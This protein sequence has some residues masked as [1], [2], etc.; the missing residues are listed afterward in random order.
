MIEL[1]PD[2]SQTMFGPIHAAPCDPYFR[3]GEFEGLCFDLDFVECK[4]LGEREKIWSLEGFLR[5]HI[6]HGVGHVDH[7]QIRNSCEGK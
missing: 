6:E 1:R 5:V 4:F 7:A 2:L 3:T